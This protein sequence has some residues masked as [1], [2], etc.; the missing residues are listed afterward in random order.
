M[1]YNMAMVPNTHTDGVPMENNGD[2]EQRTLHIGCGIHKMTGSIGLDITALPGVD[3]VLDRCVA[4]TRGG[5]AL[6]IFE[7]WGIRTVNPSA[8]VNGDVS[9]TIESKRHHVR[10]LCSL[11]HACCR[12]KNAGPAVWDPVVFH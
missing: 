12:S 11:I 3:V 8:A 10:L 9:R 2:T 4:H 7:A 6:R 1:E 5:Y